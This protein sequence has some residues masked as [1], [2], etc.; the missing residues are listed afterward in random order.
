LSGPVPGRLIRLLD[1]TRDRDALA[2]DLAVACLKD[3]HARA[4][5]GVPITDP[6]E[7]AQVLRAEMDD[8]L[9]LMAKLSLL[10]E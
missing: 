4:R 8:H 6:N 1:G 10:V 7:M 5:N 2:R 9:T 3:G